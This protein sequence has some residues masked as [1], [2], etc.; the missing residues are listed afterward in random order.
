MF[1]EIMVKRYL[2]VEWVWTVGENLSFGAE[3]LAET[4]SWIDTGKFQ[5]PALRTR[6]YRFDACLSTLIWRDGGMVD[7]TDLKSV[8][9]LGC[10]GSIPARATKDCREF[11]GTHRPLWMA[12]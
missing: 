4:Y 6:A 11:L 3:I 5:S 12:A 7:A 8:G 2:M 10:A 1:F 9:P